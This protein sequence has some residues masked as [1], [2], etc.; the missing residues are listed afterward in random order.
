MKMVGGEGR[1]NRKRWVGEV[2]KVKKGDG[3]FSGTGGRK[4]ATASVWLYERGRKPG[5]EGLMVNEKPIE[6]YF[7]GKKAESRYLR[8]LQ[9]ANVLGKFVA[10]IKV[11]GGGKEGQLDAVAHGLARALIVANPDCKAILKKEKLL[12]R[13]PRM[14]E[15]KKY[16]RRRARRRQQWSKR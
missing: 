12:T 7:P 15:R 6:V 11:A 1:E 9:V 10:S 3:F 4:T 8:P 13:D 16:G 2:G 14:K 5:L